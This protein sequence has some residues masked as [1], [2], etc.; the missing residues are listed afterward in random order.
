MKT[1]L[2]ITDGI[3]QVTLTPETEFERTII[4]GIAQRG[5][6]FRSTMIETVETRGGYL[7]SIHRGEHE[8]QSLALY[9]DP[10]ETEKPVDMA[11]F[12]AAGS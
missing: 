2:T 10:P 8:S 9:P 4:D 5:G 11:G 7:R 12:V 3:T 6:K 1:V